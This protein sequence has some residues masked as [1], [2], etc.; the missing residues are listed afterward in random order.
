MLS[1]A[2][3]LAAA[4]RGSTVARANATS[5]IRRRARRPAPAPTRGVRVG[6]QAALLPATPPRR[7]VRARCGRRRRGRRPVGAR[8]G[9]GRA[10][11]PPPRGLRARAIALRGGIRIITPPTLRDLRSSGGGVQ[12]TNPAAPRAETPPRGPRRDRRRGGDVR[13]AGVAHAAAA[14]NA[15]ASSPGSA[16]AAAAAAAAVAPAAEDVVGANDLGILLADADGDQSAEDAARA[17]KLAEV[18]RLKAERKKALQKRK[19][20]AASDSAGG[21]TEKDSAPKDLSDVAAQRERKLAEREAAKKGGKK[22]TPAEEKKAAR[23]AAAK[24]KAFQEALARGASREGGGEAGAALEE[25]A[26]DALDAAPLVAAVAAPEDSAA[27]EA[28][29]ASKA[30]SKASKGEEGVRVVLQEE[31]VV[32]RR[33]GRSRL[34]LSCPGVCAWAGAGRRRRCPGPTRPSRPARR[35][36]SSRT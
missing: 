25:D 24:E 5:S 3:P 31:G 7:R 14:A 27:E 29:K 35:R 30:S 32:R 28:S 4:P 26:G 16:P 19:A 33:G 8:R 36:G 1:A 9:R 6:R 18:R 2:R 23:I 15:S 11:R 22:L 21:E 34:G 10:R 20:D 13:A 12:R 17:R